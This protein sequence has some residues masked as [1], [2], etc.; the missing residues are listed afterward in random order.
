MNEQL[1]SLI[2]DKLVN[3]GYIVLE[4]ALSPILIEKLYVHSLYELQYKNAA[5]SN[6]KDSHID[7]NRRGDKTQWI[8]EDDDMLSE[9]LSFC[10]GLRE[11]L[12][13]SLYLGLSYYESHFSIYERGAF[14]EKHLDA[15]RGNKNRVITTLLYLNDEWSE[16]D[17]GML[18]LYDDKGE[19]LE[20][21]L[22]RGNTMLVFLSDKFPH[23]VLPTKKKCHSIAGWFRV[24]KRRER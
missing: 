13:A 8:D 12:N 24:D 3:D 20:K 7:T 23:E 17:G 16:E 2:T 21:I 18:V 22:P 1:Y 19:E 6:T 15:F 14:Y 9:Y 4:N 11:Y 10:E 5:I